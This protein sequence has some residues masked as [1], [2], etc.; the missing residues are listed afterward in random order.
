MIARARC[1]ALASAFL[2][3]ACVGHD[4]GRVA[5]RQHEQPPAPPVAHDC[6]GPDTIVAIRAGRIGSLPLD[7]TVDSLRRLCPDVRDTAASGDEELDTAIVISR[8]GLRLVGRIAA[9][10][11]DGGRHAVR[12]GASSRAD[13]WIVIGTAGE[14]P[15]RVPMTATWGT[16]V[17]AYGPTPYVERLN[18]DVTIG[19]CDAPGIGFHM[20]VPWDMQQRYDR[21]HG[22]AFDSIASAAPI[23]MLDVA[24]SPSVSPAACPPNLSHFHDA[25]T[26]P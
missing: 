8:P 13:S 6:L 11:D 18:G 24:A 23:E 14:L 26:R 22:A 1:A 20:S 10:E 7:L 25:A 12:L 19:F 21:D 5:A 15:E 9:V 16:L 4:D 3:N 2:A 17:R